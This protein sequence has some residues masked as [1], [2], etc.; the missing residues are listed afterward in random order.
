[1]LGPIML[2]CNKGIVKRIFV[3]EALKQQSV[4]VN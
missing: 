4:E 3:P 2:E 1:M